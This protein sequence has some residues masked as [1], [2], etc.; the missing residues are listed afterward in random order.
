MRERDGEGALAEEGESENEQLAGEERRRTGRVGRQ[1]ARG[2]ARGGR[3]EDAALDEDEPSFGPPHP[4][5]SPDFANVGQETAELD[6]RT[7]LEEQHERRR[8]WIPRRTETP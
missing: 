5:R 1:G 2:S 8:A 7:V 4:A 3:P 6:M